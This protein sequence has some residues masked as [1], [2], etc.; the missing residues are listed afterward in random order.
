[1]HDLLIHTSDR[2]TV[3]VDDAWTVLCLLVFRR[4]THHCE[5]RQPEITYFDQHQ[6]RV[7]SSSP[8]SNDT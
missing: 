2:V 5:Q 8:G 7:R 4:N 3:F 6:K 1:M